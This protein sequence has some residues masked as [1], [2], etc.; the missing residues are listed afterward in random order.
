MKEIIINDQTD[1][2]AIAKLFIKAAD[3]KA[4]DDNVAEV[5]ALLQ[6]VSVSAQKAGSDNA[7]AL[8]KEKIN[9]PTEEEKQVAEAHEVV[10]R[11]MKL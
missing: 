1:Y 4:T 6:Y 3:G 10:R 8:I 7:F 9:Q 11:I 2:K 5:T